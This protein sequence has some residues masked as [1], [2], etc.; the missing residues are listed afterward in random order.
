MAQGILKSYYLYRHVRLDTNEVFYIGV[1]T[2]N[3]KHLGFPSEY[4]RAY[5]KNNRSNHWKNIIN[6]T[7]YNVEILFESDCL[8]IIYEKERE[9]IELYG[10]KDLNKGTLVNHNNG[11]GGLEDSKH[12][13]EA[14][15]KIS[16]SNKGRISAMLNKKHSEETKLKIGLANKGKKLTIKQKEIL[17][18]SNSG[19]NNNKAKFTDDDIIKIRNNYSSGNFKQR[20]LAKIFNTD[21]GTIS[22][23]V[24]H[25]KWKHI[26]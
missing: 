3:N 8:S 5:Y 15:K 19:M 20:E 26:L 16:E 10:R 12:T 25:K 6:K 17:S 4:K 14:K 13:E 9:F 22:S 24:N 11:G 1:G 21:Q 23:I 7:N 2:K 18:I